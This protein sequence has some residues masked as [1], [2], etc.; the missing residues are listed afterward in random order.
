MLAAGMIPLNSR[1]SNHSS[2]D[3]QILEDERLATAVKPRSILDWYRILRAHHRWTM[4]QAIR[5]ALWL[6]R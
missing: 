5:Y 3:P 4:F 2:Y 1:G 6:A